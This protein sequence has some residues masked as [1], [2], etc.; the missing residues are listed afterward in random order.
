MLVE[1]RC[2]ELPVQFSSVPVSVR[3]LREL[4]LQA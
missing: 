3:T 4:S 2:T 1:L